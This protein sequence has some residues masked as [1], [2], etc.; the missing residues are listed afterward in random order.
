M[1]TPYVGEIRLFAGNFAPHDWLICDG[2]LLD[3][4]IYPE[5]F[6]LFGNIFGGDGRTNFAVPDMR[7]RIPV[8]AGQRPGSYPYTLG[9]EIGERDC[10][11]TVAHVPKHTHRVRA[12]TNAAD[13]VMP[14]PTNMLAT[15][16]KDIRLYGDTTKPTSPVRNF[17]AKAIGTTGGAAIAGH[18]N[19]MPSLPL[20]Y[21]I[22]TTG[23]YPQ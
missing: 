4:N 7:G 22:A 9:E 8:G 1:A 2:S 5:L 20:N 10:Y 3:P 17:S 13:Q 14:G 15:G 16:A 19:M 6:S 21:I 11:L 23:V 12:S 18:N